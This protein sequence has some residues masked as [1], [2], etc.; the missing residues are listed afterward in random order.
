MSKVRSQYIPF[1]S[2]YPISCQTKNI[3]PTIPHQSEV[4][5]RS[6]CDARIK[7]RAVL[8]R[9]AVEAL[10]AELEHVGGGLAKSKKREREEGSDYGA[11]RLDSMWRIFAR[12]EKK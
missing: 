3:Q 4:R 1:L 8:D 6:D 5:R 9:I 12:R 7:E 2:D 10:G 11:C